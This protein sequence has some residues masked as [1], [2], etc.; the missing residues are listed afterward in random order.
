M[1]LSFKLVCACR[2]RTRAVAMPVAVCGEHVL[3]I[4]H[5]GLT[6]HDNRRRVGAQPR[7]NQAAW[8]DRPVAA[9]SPSAPW[10]TARRD[11]CHRHHRALSPRAIMPTLIMTLPF[12][13]LGPRAAPARR[14]HPP[15]DRLRRLVRA[16]FRSR[17]ADAPPRPCRPA[18]GGRPQRSRPGVCCRQVRREPRRLQARRRRLWRWYRD[19]PLGDA[20]GLG[21][22]ARSAQ[23]DILLRRP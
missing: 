6:D 5:R 12:I 17:R 10:W 4:R 20:G 15:A 13:G 19:P 18:V 11:G 16:P 23:L 9:R 7:R 22:I 8:P 2:P 1:P 3:R 21:R 14:A